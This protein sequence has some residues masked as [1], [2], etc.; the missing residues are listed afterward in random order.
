MKKQRVKILQAQNKELTQSQDFQDHEGHAIYVLRA[1]R[2][3]ARGMFGTHETENLRISDV[4]VTVTGAS[5][6]PV[7][8]RGHISHD[9][10]TIH[11]H[12]PRDCLRP[13]TT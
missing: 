2:Q 1:P 9:P 13:N 7:F 10:V 6:D 8:V 4:Y 11:R 3:R 5:R 12:K